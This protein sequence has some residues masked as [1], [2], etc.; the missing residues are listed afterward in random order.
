MAAYSFL[1]NDKVR[2]VLGVDPGSRVT[3]YAVLEGGDGA[4][5]VV[6]AGII[7]L[8]PKAPMWVRLALLRQE[9]KEV[10]QKT[11]PNEA[12]VER[13]FVSRNADSA[14]K[15]GHARG[16]VLVTLHEAGLPIYE[17]APAMVKKAVSRR[18]RAEKSQLAGILRSIFGVSE[19]LHADAADALAIGFCHL[20]MAQ[21]RGV[22]SGSVSVSK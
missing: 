17:Y 13:V 11:V 7:V 15:L 20:L 19:D 9:L 1:G 22:L 3:G 5:T 21:E 16:V 4:G 12:A 14:L 6:T 10:L 18:G 8:D 2:R